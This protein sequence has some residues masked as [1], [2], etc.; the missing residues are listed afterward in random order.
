MTDAIAA[1]EVEKRIEILV[2]ACRNAGLRMTSQRLEIFKEVAQTGEHPDAE[3][4]FSRVRK[5]IPN[6]SL[7][8]VYR[9]L[10]QLEQLGILS[11][12]DPLCGRARFD[13]NS[14]THHHFVCVRCHAVIDFY[15]KE[16]EKIVVPQ[17]G[18][19]LGEVQSLHLQARGLC[20]TCRAKGQHK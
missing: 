5:S 11:R 20:R 15:L 17:M 7:D 3:T 14:D 19:R 10:T 8:T 2:D 9:N 12:V 6:I 18:E 4:V 1:K 16:N 13:A